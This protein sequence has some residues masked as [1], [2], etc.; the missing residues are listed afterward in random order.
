MV[1]KKKV[2]ILLFEDNPGDANLI[3]EMLEEF[4]DFPYELKNVETL[5]EGLEFLKEHQFDVILSDLRLPDSDGTETFL[6]IHA[7]NSRVPIIILTGISDE[8]TGID[9][10]KKGAQDY[11]VKGQVDGRLLNRSIRYSIERKRAEEELQESEERYRIITEQ[12][13]QLIYDFNI[14]ENRVRWA[15]AIEEITGY[16]AEEFDSMELSSWIEKKFIP[17]TSNPHLKGSML[18]EEKEESLITSSGSR[19]KMGVI[20]MSKKTGFTFRMKTETL[21]EYL[22]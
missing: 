21:T 12:T 17:K 6:D 9:A 19:K 8:N 20:S 18:F 10:V 14:K 16:T 3:E 2:K 1:W 22:G 11:L 15:G 7:T 13:G 5:K 4:A